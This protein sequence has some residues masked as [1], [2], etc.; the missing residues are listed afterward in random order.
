M[1]GL[2]E[3]LDDRLVLLVDAI[4]VRW[5][6]R[7]RRNGMCFICRLLAYSLSASTRMRFNEKRLFINAR[8]TWRRQLKFKSSVQMS[9]LDRGEKHLVHAKLMLNR[10]S[11]L[12]HEI[13]TTIRNSAFVVY[14]L[15]VQIKVLCLA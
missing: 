15:D 14:L 13:K 12:S 4:L 5:R 7:V 2:R 1:G 10:K 6:L 8:S 11:F 3:R 9:A